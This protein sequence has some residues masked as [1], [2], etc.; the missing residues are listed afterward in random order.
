LE[1]DQEDE[2]EDEDG[3]DD[4]IREH[5]RVINEDRERPGKK[6]KVMVVVG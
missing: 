1:D 5:T 4:E 3:I 6:P 2:D